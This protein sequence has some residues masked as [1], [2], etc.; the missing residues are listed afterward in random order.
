MVITKLPP[1]EIKWLMCTSGVY[2]QDAI[3]LSFLF[4][5]PHM[6]LII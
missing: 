4:I 3:K 1:L 6:V 2:G 5:F